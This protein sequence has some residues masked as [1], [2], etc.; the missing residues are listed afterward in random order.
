[1]GTRFLCGG[2]VAI[3]AIVPICQSLV[4]IVH[5]HHTYFALAVHVHM[6]YIVINEEDS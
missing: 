1:M 6:A 2:F 5:V 3:A 4:N